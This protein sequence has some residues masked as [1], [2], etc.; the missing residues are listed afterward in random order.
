MYR[1]TQSDYLWKKFGD[2]LKDFCISANEKISTLKCKE[3]LRC[4][5]SINPTPG[6]ASYSLV[7]T[8]YSWFIT[9]EQRVW[10]LNLGPQLF[11]LSPKDRSPKHL[12]LK[13]SR[14]CVHGTHMDM[15]NEEVTEVINGHISTHCGLSPKDSA[16][17][18]QGKLPISQSFF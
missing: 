18:E 12:P 14:S 13:T 7:V 6:I 4:T 17:M 8:L 9:K 5:L 2:C 11:R 3:I 1:Y 16:Q 15:A 10:T